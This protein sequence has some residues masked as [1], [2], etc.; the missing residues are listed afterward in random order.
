MTEKLIEIDE[1]HLSTE[2]VC[3]NEIENEDGFQRVEADALSYDKFFT[4]F[5]RTNKPVVIRGIADYWECQ[6]WIQKETTINFDYLRLKIDVDANVPVANCNRVFYNSHEK[7]QMKFG[8]F[9]D[10]WA[11]RIESDEDNSH[12]NDLFYLKD[13]HLRN[14]HPQYRFYET[15]IY[16]T[17][18]WL[19]EFCVENQR[20]DYRFVYMGPKDSW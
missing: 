3:E 15:P 6:N 17:S 1:K 2:F 12:E 8:H 11:K 5:M 9:L 7:K 18:D 14:Q 19:N 13:W 4:T 16:F 10:Y 20:D